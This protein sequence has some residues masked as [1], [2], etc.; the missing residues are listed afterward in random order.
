MSKETQIEVESEIEVITLPA[1]TLE[2]CSGISTALNE[3]NASNLTADKRM[4]TASA[5]MLKVMGLKPNYNLLKQVQQV[6]LNSLVNDHKL[7]LSTSEKLFSQMLKQVQFSND[8]FVKPSKPTPDAKR[9]S[10]K[11]KELKE[12]YSH[13]AIETVETE[14]AKIN[15]V[16]GQSFM[17]NV[18]PKEE[19]I[20]LQKELNEVKKIKSE[21]L[22]S[23]QKEVQG[24]N[25]KA[26]VAQ[27]QK[28]M[29][30]DTGRFNKKSQPIFEWSV[31]KLDFVHRCLESSYAVTK[32]LAD[33][34]PFD[35]NK[36]WQDEKK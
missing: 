31:V 7:A 6:I 14:L 15:R 20:K 3:S 17:D 34:P 25:I 23:E 22:V 33:K 30:Q 24:N 9:V 18:K 32:F 8:K 19:D 12:K 13:T 16:I 29:K 5:L 36:N 26:L 27:V 35:V 21:K 10:A 2:A 1:K 4:N 11:R 28:M